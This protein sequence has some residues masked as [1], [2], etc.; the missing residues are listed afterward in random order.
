MKIRYVT[1]VFLPSKFAHA[2][3]FIKQCEGFADAG[4]DVVLL[5]AKKKNTTKD[6]THIY[7]Y[8]GVKNKFPIIGFAM[9]QSRVGKLCYRFNILCYLT[10]NKG[11]VYTRDRRFATLSTLIGLKT[12][13]E[14][15]LPLNF[16]GIKNNRFWKYLYSKSIKSRHMVK[17]IVISEALKQ[18][19][20]SHVNTNKIFVAPDASNIPTGVAKMDL[21]RNPRYLLEAGYT[22]QLYPGKGME[23]IFEIAKIIDNVRFHIVGGLDHDLTYWKQKVQNEGLSN[24]IFYGYVANKDISFYLKSFDICLLPNKK[25]IM[26]S[27]NNVDIGSFTSPLKMFDY[28]AHG[29]PIIA[30]DLPILREVLNETNAILCDPE[31][32]QEW[33]NAIT[34]LTADPSLRDRLGKKAFADFEK[35]YTWKIRAERIIDSILQQSDA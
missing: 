22:G 16:V 20:I 18:T 31:N 24:I 23:I 3:H 6:Y 30:S 19:L 12:I 25:K 4:H 17:I 34:K 27:C 7:N 26:I 10:K 28:M 14:L 29:K 33:V 15:H 5:H 9:H 21:K 8:Y 13:L 1:D 32:T 35:N 2:I 11:L